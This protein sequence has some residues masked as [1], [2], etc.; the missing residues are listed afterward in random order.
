MYFTAG[1]LI[2]SNPYW[3]QHDEGSGKKIV[4]NG[5]FRIKRTLARR[6]NYW[7]LTDTGQSSVHLEQL[8]AIHISLE[9]VPKPETVKI[10]GKRG[11]KFC[12]SP[13][14]AVITFPRTVITVVLVIVSSRALSIIGQLISNQTLSI[15][16]MMPDDCWWPAVR[17]VFCFTAGLLV[18][19]HEAR[20]IT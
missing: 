13:I 8:I 5:T 1:C 7:S 17:A 14:K 3:G 4:A 16:C 15:R 12:H 20:R 2:Q 11:L 9:S 18:D 10:N 6:R 19:C